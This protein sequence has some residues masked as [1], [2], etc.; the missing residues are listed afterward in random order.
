MASSPPPNPSQGPFSRALSRSRS[1]G[2]SVA[3]HLDPLIERLNEALYNK[4]F[5]ASGSSATVSGP[6]S[7]SRSV[8]TGALSASSSG[9]NTSGLGSGSDP[10]FPLRIRILLSES[11]LLLVLLLLRFSLASSDISVVDRPLL[12]ITP[13]PSL[14]SSALV[15]ICCSSK[16]NADKLVTEMLESGYALSLDYANFI[17]HPGNLFVKNLQTRLVSADGLRDFFN[18]RSRY[19]S[20][21]DVNLFANNADPAESFA[22]VKFANYLDVEYLLQA[23]EMANPFHDADVPLY[24]NN[25]ISKKERKLRHDDESCPAP[26]E[27]APSPPPTLGQINTHTYETVV[28]ENLDEFLNP[29]NPSL[30]LMYDFFAKFEIFSRI[31]SIYFPLENSPN[32]ASLV[33]KNFGYINFELSPGLNVSVLKCLYYLNNLTFTEFINFSEDDLY[34]ISTDLNVADPEE[35][36]TAEPR[37]KISISQHRHNHYLFHFNPALPQQFVYN[38]PRFGAPDDLQLTV[39]F[40]DVTLHDLIVNKFSKVLNFQETNIYVSNFPVVFENNDALWE[41][42]W[43]QFGVGKVKSAKI[44]KPQFYSKANNGVKQKSTEA[45]GKIGF[46][47]YESLKMALRAILLTNDRVV[48]LGGDPSTNVVIQTSFAIQKSHNSGNKAPNAGAN[49]P[50]LQ[51]SLLPFNYHPNGYMKRFSLPTLRDSSLSPSTYSPPP[52][53]SPPPSV[54]P[55][56]EYVYFNPYMFAYNY[57]MMS[58]PVTCPPEDGLEELMASLPPPPPII[59]PYFYHQSY[60]LYLPPHSMP[61]QAV[62]SPEQ[63]FSNSFTAQPGPEPHKP[64]VKKNSLKSR[65]SPGVFFC[66]CPSFSFLDFNV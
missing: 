55:H 63:Y 49:H 66:K 42:F 29:L 46:V 22:I 41:Q 50:F 23:P 14:P 11:I 52:R 51:R 4:E 12:P 54:L 26:P 8:D 21:A 7:S 34:D 25:Y 60:Y 40:L 38:Q 47:F 64:P 9:D 24:L 61:V 35:S 37:L 30:P 59:N 62:V 27:T 1:S 2:P 33:L 15:E 32:D 3:G 19:A 36:D 45:L 10:Y 6:A 31:E 57:P 48:N 39:S 65:K 5:S 58:P 16:P 53:T 13:A 18:D 44:I 17:S 56:P 28:V 20:I 43:S